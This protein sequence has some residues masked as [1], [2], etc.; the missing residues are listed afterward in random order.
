MGKNFLSTSEEE[1]IRITVAFESGKYQDFDKCLIFA[2]NK[3]P[4]SP[5]E[6]VSFLPV[7]M[8]DADIERAVLT[9]TKSV[10]AMKVEIAK[11][12]IKKM[13][14]ERFE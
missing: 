6:T 4:A 8:T 3:N 10:E 7:N 5:L 14:G 1:A 12:F 13:V 2:V 9:M 11:E